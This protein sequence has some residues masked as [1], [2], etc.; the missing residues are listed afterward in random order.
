MNPKVILESWDNLENLDFSEVFMIV[1]MQPFFIWEN[2]LPNTVKLHYHSLRSNIIRKMES[3]LENGW[4]IVNIEYTS[5]W[6]LMRW[7]IKEIS[8]ILSQNKQNVIML[9]KH[10]SWLLG[11]VHDEE[12]IQQQWKS[13]RT[14]DFIKQREVSIQIS[15]IH[16]SKCVRNTAKDIKSYW[17]VTRVLMWHILN[18]NDVDT[19]F[20]Q[21]NQLCEVRADYWKSWHLLDYWGKPINL[22]SLTD[23]L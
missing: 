3:V 7:T 21:S 5:T 19:T 17:C 23:Y 18:L 13:K 15:G 10:S 2:S 8:S 9:E 4:L 16:A 22:S 14:L 1:D 12:W 6:W 20:E 11:F